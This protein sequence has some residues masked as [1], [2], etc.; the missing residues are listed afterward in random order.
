M[1]KSGTAVVAGK[2]ASAA[3]GTAVALRVSAMATRLAAMLE[4]MARG[5]TPVSDVDCERELRRAGGS[6]PIAMAC[7]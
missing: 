4:G 6:E 7:E 2:V 1:G 3:A 5:A